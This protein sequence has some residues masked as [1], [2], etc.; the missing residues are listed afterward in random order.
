MA[1]GKRKQHRQTPLFV[2][3][4]DLPSGAS[5]PFYAKLNEVLAGWKFD[6]FVEGLCDKF[7]DDTMGPPGSGPGEDFPPPHPPPPPPPPPHSSPNPPPTPPNPP[8]PPHP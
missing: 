5:H 3:A 1:M 8:P 4:L 6:E 2:S 7:Y